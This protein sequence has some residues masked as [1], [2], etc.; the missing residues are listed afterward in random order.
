M[1]AL[2]FAKGL[3]QR[4]HS[5]QVLT[6]FPN[7]P[8]GKIFKGYKLKFYQKDVIEDILIHRVLLYPSHDLGS[9]R[10]SL[11]Y[12]S[13]AIFAALIGPWVVR[14]KIDVIY[15]YH[16]PATVMFPALIL[17]KIKKAGILLDVNDLWPD[18]ITSTG[19]INKKLPLKLITYWMNYS[20]RKANKINVLST[21]IKNLLEQRGVAKGKIVSIPVW[22]NESLINYELDTDFLKTYNLH[23]CFIAIYAGAMGRAQN[24]STFIMAAKRLQSIIPTFKMIF[25]GHGVC[26]EELKDMV[27]KNDIVNIIFVPVKPPEEL[28]AILNLADV[29]LI[30]LK[31]DPLFAVTIPSKIAYYFAIGKPIVAGLEGDAADI[32]IKSGGG[33]VCTPQDVNEI[34]DGIEQIYKMDVAQRNSI[35][36]R[37]KKYYRDNFSMEEGITNFE[38]IMEDIV[39]M[40]RNRKGCLDKKI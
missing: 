15:V 35:A 16:P 31:K 19:M 2:I 7:Y 20:Y 6:G 27:L 3:K 26:L 25:I 39:K 33:I 17:H 9:I 21:G 29:L 14:G 13:F 23:N 8:M 22:C 38:E 28:T 10:R 4:G 36:D 11:N 30:H 32:I 37:G 18:T 34:A 5:V 12:S 1:K 24:L 40:G